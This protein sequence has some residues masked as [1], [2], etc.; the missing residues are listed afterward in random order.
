MAPA[1]VPVVLQRWWGADIAISRFYGDRCDVEHIVILYPSPFR[2]I[3]WTLRWRRHVMIITPAYAL[4]L[5]GGCTDARRTVFGY[6][7]ELEQEEPCAE[8]A[9]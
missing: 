3:D 4:E 7:P 9:P 1:P 2:P 8:A 6:A 5:V